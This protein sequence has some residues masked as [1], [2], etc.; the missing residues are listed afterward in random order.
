[1]SVEP[2]R[3][4]VVSQ[5]WEAVLKFPWQYRTGD[6][7]TPGHAG[8]VILGN[9]AEYLACPCVQ[10]LLVNSSVVDPQGLRGDIVWGR[11]FSIY[12]VIN[13]TDSLP[14]HLHH[15]NRIGRPLGLRDSTPD[16]VHGH[17]VPVSPGTITHSSPT[18]GRV[19]RTSRGSWCPTSACGGQFTALTGSG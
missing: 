13:L 8:H 17:L 10:C 2:D 19:D 11:V 15:S 16:S 5:W 12:S 9:H 3:S 4:S 6:Q 14:P 7:G 1:M 18:W